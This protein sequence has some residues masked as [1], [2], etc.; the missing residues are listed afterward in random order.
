MKLISVGY[1]PP[2]WMR[3]QSYIFSMNFQKATRFPEDL[4][5]F[6]VPQ[7]EVFSESVLKM[8]I[9]KVN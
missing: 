3:T 4:L 7:K 6:R 9:C 2:G 5:D 8:Y 1:G